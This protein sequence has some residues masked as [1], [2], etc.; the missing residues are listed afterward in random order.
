MKPETKISKF[1]FDQDRGPAWKPAKADGAS[2]LNIVIF[3]ITFM[4]KITITICI[5]KPGSGRLRQAFYISSFA[6]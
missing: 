3:F 1:Q 4:V 6:K 2:S 5:L